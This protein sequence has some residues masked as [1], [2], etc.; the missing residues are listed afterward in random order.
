MRDYLSYG[1]AKS[2]CEKHPVITAI[3]IALIIAAIVAIV[4]AI[5]NEVK[6]EQD[7]LDE[8][9]DLDDEDDVYFYPNEEDFV[10]GE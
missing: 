6:R 10:E 7:L 9:W 8:E 2:C 5:V 3:V 1:R 4:V